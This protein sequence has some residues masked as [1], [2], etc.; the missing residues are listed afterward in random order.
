[1]ICRGSQ[2]LPCLRGHSVFFA[3]VSLF[4][5]SACPVVLCGVLCVSL[6]LDDRDAIDIHGAAW[7]VEYVVADLSD[8][9]GPTAIP[10][11]RPGQ[12]RTDRTGW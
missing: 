7:P 2:V 12:V 8:F 5:Y 3:C 6:V 1:M 4:C 9:Q 11:A 10:V